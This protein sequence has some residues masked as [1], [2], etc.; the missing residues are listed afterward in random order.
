M[1]TRLALMGIALLAT[2]EVSGQSDGQATLGPV[3]E[4]TVGLWLTDYLPGDTLFFDL[5][6]VRFKPW[7]KGL[8]DARQVHDLE[9]HARCKASGNIRQ[10]LTPYGVEIVEIP[11]LR[12]L[13]IFDIG[14]PHTYREVFMDGRSHPPDLA[15]TNYGHNIGWWDGATLVVDSVG[16]NEDSWFERYGLPF[17]E[18]VH[19]TEFFTR[20]GPDRVEY[21]FVI[22]DPKTYDAPVE[23]RLDLYW[24]EGEELFEYI[25]QQS[26]YAH[27]LMLNPEE[28]RAIGR[29]SPIVP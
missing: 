4:Q 6:A 28:M 20:L 5:D 16:Y 8:F 22:D 18:S 29:S 10:F 14:G 21:R 15:P 19:V 3:G 23:G 25:C 24:Q 7:A 11:E 13:Y 26:N 17:T 12:R 1:T 2:A 27:D 9:P